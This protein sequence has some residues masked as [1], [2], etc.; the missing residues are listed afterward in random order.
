MRGRDSSSVDTGS[1][2]EPGLYPSWLPP[3]H[4]L[5]SYHNSRPLAGYEKSMSLLTNSQMSAE[6]LDKLVDKAWRMFTSKAYVHQYTRHGLSTDHFIDCFSMMEHVIY[7]YSNLP[8]SSWQHSKLITYQLFY[9][10][11][12]NNENK[13][14]S[15]LLENRYWKSFSSD[16]FHGTQKANKFSAANPHSYWSLV[17]Q[18]L[19][20]HSTANGTVDSQHEFTDKSLCQ[21]CTRHVRTLHDLLARPSLCQACQAWVE[22]QNR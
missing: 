9:L 20:C 16:I 13:D 17:W 11:N 10:F 5:G 22:F 21:P 7:N 8:P 4:T 15:I 12:K 14:G 19:E 3:A 1:L 2:R 18:P 6:P